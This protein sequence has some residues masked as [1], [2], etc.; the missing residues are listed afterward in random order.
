MP[1]SAHCLQHCWLESF[2]QLNVPAPKFSLGQSVVVCWFDPARSRTRRDPGR[3]I[4][5]TISH[6]HYR[7]GGW[8]YFVRMEVSADYP[9]LPAGYVDEVPEFE[10]EGDAR[11]TH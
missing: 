2:S 9:H 1:E 11:A 8:W 7:I 6:G 5:L 10:L 4:G 3:I